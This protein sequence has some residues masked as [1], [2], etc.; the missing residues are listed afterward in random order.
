MLVPPVDERFVVGSL[1]AYFPVY[2]RHAVVEPAVVHPQQ[3]VGIEV[4]VVLQSVGI[5]ADAAGALVAV[6]AERRDAH[7]HPRLGLVDG[8]IELLNEEVHVVAAPV[9]TVTNAIAILS[10]L[11]IVGYGLSSCGI[12]I[13]VVVHVDTVHVVAGDDVAC[14]LADVVA[15]LWNA[16]IQDGQPVILEAV[17]RLALGYVVGSQQGS[18]LGTGTVGVN[19]CVQL[20]TATMALV[21]HPAQGVPVRRRGL[22]L[23]SGKE[24]APRLDAT[25]VE[26]VTLRTYLKDNGVHT[27]APQL[28]QLVAE[29]LLHLLRPHSLELTVNTLNP[30]TAHFALRLG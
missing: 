4:V 29:R 27:V 24:T 20:H 1:V 30:G 21:N 15:V 7:L 19:P 23:P 17:L 28:V 5:A 3:H 12:G 26:G 18:A 13:K 16:G 14:H 25:F 2:L 6:D 8:L 22:S 9:A 10:E 11:R